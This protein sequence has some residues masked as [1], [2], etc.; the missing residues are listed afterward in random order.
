[1]SL[2]DCICFI[3]GQNEETYELT[4]HRTSIQIELDP[5]PQVPPWLEMGFS[6]KKQQRYPLVM[7]NIA[8]V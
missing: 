4:Y 3:L 5:C 2:Y 7:T 6:Q 8:M 1:M